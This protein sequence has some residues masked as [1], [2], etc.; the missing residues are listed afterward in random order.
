MN[1]PFYNYENSLLSLVILLFLKSNLSN[2]SKYSNLLLL[3]IIY[4][5]IFKIHLLKSIFWVLLFIY[6]N[7]LCFLNWGVSLWIFNIY[8]V[9]FLSTFLLFAFSL[10]SLSH[11]FPCSHLPA[12]FGLFEY[13]LELHFNISIGFLARPFCLLTLSS[14]IFIQLLSP[15]SEFFYVRYRIFNFWNLNLVC[16]Y[17]FDFSPEIFNLS[18]PYED[19][20]FYLSE[21]G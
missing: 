11:F 7:Y 1:W 18:I 12:Y 4:L 17:S 20:L 14:V 8:A 6:S 3:K 13:F 10:S 19:I 5:F 15:S 9:G 21:H 2:I 16:F